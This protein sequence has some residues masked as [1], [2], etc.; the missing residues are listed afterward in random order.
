MTESK[1]CKSCDM[2]IVEDTF[3]PYDENKCKKCYDEEKTD[4]TVN[5]TTTLQDDEE[6]T[7]VPDDK[8][9]IKAGE[10]FYICQCCGKPFKTLDELNKHN[11][12]DNGEIKFQ[13]A[14]N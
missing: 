12:S 3:C 2:E 8:Y 14:Q 5:S 11:A 13:W 9:T 1:I 4:E 10:S 7:L 6:L